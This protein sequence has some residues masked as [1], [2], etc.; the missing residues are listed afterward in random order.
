MEA[1]E[2]I[3]ARVVCDSLSPFG[4][5]LT[6]LEVTF[7]RFVLAE[8][9][10]HR[11]FSRNSASSRAIPTA[12]LL[13]RVRNNPAMP[14]EWGA[15]NAGMQSKSL[16]GEEEAKVLKSY[17]IRQAHAAAEAAEKMAMVGGHKQI[18][19]RIIEPYLWH[20]VIVTATE[21]ENFYNLRIS[22]FAQPEIRLAAERM[23]EA[24]S[25]SEPKRVGFGAWHLPFVQDDELGGLISDLVR[26]SIARCARVSYLTH[27]GIR[28]QSSDLKLYDK[29]ETSGHWSPFEHAATPAFEANDF[30]ANFK[31]W[32]QQRFFKE[33]PHLTAGYMEQL[34]T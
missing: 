12:K 29:L 25:Q 18:V 21:W 22:E 33:N 31:G 28:D 5:R 4:K 2:N 17:W 19:N 7:P 13:E 27:D 32:I 24:I 14:I 6:T 15:N 9:N 11:V 23:K 3:Q 30:Y 20:T 34:T 16:L 8:F 1:S 10:T 26:I